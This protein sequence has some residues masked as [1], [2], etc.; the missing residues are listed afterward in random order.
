MAAEVPFPDT[1]L[2]RVSSREALSKSSNSQYTIDLGNAISDV[3]DGIRGISVTGIGFCNC[4]PNIV[5]DTVF[6]TRGVGAPVVDAVTIPRG[7]YT[8][9]QLRDLLIA[10]LSNVTSIVLDSQGYVVFTGDGNFANLFGSAWAL[11]GFS[12]NQLTD[13]GPVVTAVQF[14]NLQ[15]L[16][17]AFL[18]SSVLADSQH[19][20]DSEGLLVSFLTHVPITVPYQTMQT[21]E[22]FQHVYP[23]IVYKTPLTPRSINIT[24]R[25]VTGRVVDVGSSEL[26]VVFRLWI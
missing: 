23:S 25:D 21:H 8:F 16:Q 1:R 3:A 22:P 6:E 13:P 19:A 20:L 4:D 18:H 9:E 15:G 24:L 7:Q 17:V 26:W 2:L 14:P 5:E 10:G 11:L 12:D